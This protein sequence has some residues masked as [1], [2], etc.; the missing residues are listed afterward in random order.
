MTLRALGCRRMPT[1]RTAAWCLLLL[2]LSAVAAPLAAGD[3]C[4]EP[5]GSHCGDCAWC[6]VAADMTG[7]DDAMGLSSADLRSSPPRRSALAVPRTLDHV[8]LLA[9]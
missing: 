6:P 1:P 5:C 7:V 8:P 4:D 2:V 9:R 3:G